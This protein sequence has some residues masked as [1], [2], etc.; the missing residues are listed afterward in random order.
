MVDVHDVVARRKPLEDVARHDARIAF[1]RRT[2]T[3]PN[4]S[5]SV[6]NARPCGPPSEPA[7]EAP[8]DERHRA[9]AAAARRPVTTATGCPASTRISASRG[10][11]S[12]REHDSGAAVAPAARQ[13]RQGASP[14]PAGARLAPA[15]QV[16]RRTGRRDAIP[17]PRRLRF[18]RSSSVRDAPAG[19]AS[20]AAAGRS[21]P[22]L[23][24][25]AG[26]TSSR[27]ALVRLAP[28]ESSASARSPGSSSTAASRIDVVEAGR[29]R[30]LDGPDL[31]RIP[32]GHG[33]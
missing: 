26:S 4:S 3:E 11:C 2:R 5:R 12:E 9:Q 13:R 1:G 32:D 18:P 14:G 10:A 6:T 15:E 27:A 31:G 29:G 23:R 7:V 16:A 30:E 28:Q 19:A 20:R 8:L 24:Q 17:A 22:V 33:P 21:R 25:V